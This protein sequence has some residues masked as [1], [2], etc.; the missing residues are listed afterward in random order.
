MSWP[1]MVA[2]LGVPL[3]CALVY[4]VWIPHGNGGRSAW[5][6][7]KIWVLVYPLFFFSLIGLG[8]LIRREDRVAKW[9]SWR[10]V[11]LTGFLTGVGVA[12]VGWLMAIGTS[13][14]E[15]VKANSDN[16]VEKARGLGFATPGRFLM[17]AAFITLLHSAMEEYYW[18]W[19]VYGHLRQMVGHWPGHFIAA[20]AFTGHHL[21]LMSVL[22]PLPLALFLSFLTG[23]GGLIW[24]LMYEWQGT[25]L[26]CWISHLVMDAFLMIVGYRLI[27][28]AVI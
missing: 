24:T 17:L 28:G 12:L 5:F 23:L 4:M 18:R 7:T 16:L 15:I 25:V 13:V 19:F 6:A 14:G 22:F 9:P 3:L 11:I 2:A 1:S 8:G 26:G 20:L 21:V 27:M 10:V